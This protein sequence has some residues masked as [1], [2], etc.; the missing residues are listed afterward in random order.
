MAVYEVTANTPG[1]LITAENREANILV[2]T[3][4]VQALTI[5]KDA[6][7][8]L[9]LFKIPAG[10]STVAFTMREDLAGPLYAISPAGMVVQVNAWR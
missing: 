6:A 1:T 7:G 2:C 9:P 8:T 10:V 4:G 5:A 3:T